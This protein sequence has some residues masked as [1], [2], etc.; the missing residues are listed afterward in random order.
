MASQ[1]LENRISA[2]ASSQLPDH[3]RHNY[4]TFVFFAEAYY[5][6]LEQKKMPQEIIQNLAQYSSIDDTVDE[7]IEY[8]YK[9]YCAD[10]PVNP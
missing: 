2:L 4:E 7:F 1:F 9:K 6:Y 3:I 8:F 10:F 5:E